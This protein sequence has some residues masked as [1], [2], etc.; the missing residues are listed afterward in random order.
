MSLAHK[1]SLCQKL[2]HYYKILHCAAM[3]KFTSFA[4][5]NLTNVATKKKRVCLTLG[6]FSSSKMKKNISGSHLSHVDQVVHMT[7]NFTLTTTSYIQGGVI[8]D[9]K[10]CSVSPDASTA[11]KRSNVLPVPKLSLIIT[12]V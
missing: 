4:I 12:G 5:S 11:R 7:V 10:H 1:R 9:S 6:L 2:F 3:K 8:S